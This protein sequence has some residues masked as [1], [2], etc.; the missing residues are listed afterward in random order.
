MI[1]YR[2]GVFL[3]E[4]SIINHMETAQVQYSEEEVVA[5]YPVHAFMLYNNDI[6]TVILT[7]QKAAIK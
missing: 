4:S 6:I 7:V 1:A 2:Y 5:K 3:Q